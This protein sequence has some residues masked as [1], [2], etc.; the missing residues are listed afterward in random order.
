M[1]NFIIIIAL[2]DQREKNIFTKIEIRF[3]RLLLNARQH[4]FH[5]YICIFFIYF[6]LTHIQLTEI[7]FWWIRDKNA[8]WLKF[9]Q[10]KWIRDF[11]L[12]C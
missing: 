10:K 12:Y 5:I 2:Y 8:I 7:V 9:C 11:L 6:H 3:S 4:R 1:L